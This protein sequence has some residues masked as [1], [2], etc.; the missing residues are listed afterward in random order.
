MR[1][2][3]DERRTQGLGHGAVSSRSV[4]SVS[5]QD[6]LDRVTHWHAPDLTI[7][8]RRERHV[9]PAHRG[10]EGISMIGQ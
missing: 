7:E 10:N 8:A 4:T 9:A 3:D 5:K 2:A 1:K 6:E